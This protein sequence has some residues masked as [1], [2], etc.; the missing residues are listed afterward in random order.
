MFLSINLEIIICKVP[1][2]STLSGLILEIIQ[3][4]QAILPGSKLDLNHIKIFKG[5]QISFFKM[6]LWTLKFSGPIVSI[7]LERLWFK[8][9]I[10]CVNQYYMKRILKGNNFL[11]VYK[12]FISPFQ[13]NFTKFSSEI[14][15][16]FKTS[17]LKYFSRITG[18][19]D[20][21][22]Y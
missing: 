1:Y 7:H 18:T 11:H 19:C 3:Q 2:Q 4:T 6:F 22:S 8:P 16:Q 10:N 14:T 21:I 13:A 15:H 5:I 12:L 20:F 17:F 9:D